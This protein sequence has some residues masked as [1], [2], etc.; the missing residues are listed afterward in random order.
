MGYIYSTYILEAAERAGVLV[1]NKP[2]SLRDCNEKIYA[3][4]F[5][6][7]CPPVLVTSNHSLL[8]QFHC[9]HGDVI[10]KPLEGMGGSG[11]FRVKQDDP[12]IGVILE[13]LTGHQKHQI[14]AQ[15]FIPDISNGD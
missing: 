10:F 12:N 2:Q 6:Q 15:K 4:Q 1:V 11:I 14:M 13:T 9:E 8:R 5:P 3:T 7:C